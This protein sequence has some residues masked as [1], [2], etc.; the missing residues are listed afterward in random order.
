MLVD[1]LSCCWFHFPRFESPLCSG[2][3]NWR[4][5]I[6]QILNPYLDLDHLLM[7]SLV[8]LPDPEKRKVGG[9]LGMI[10]Y[11]VLFG[12]MICFGAI[13]SGLFNSAR[14]LFRR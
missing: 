5:V 12:N 11:L 10:C 6:S 7:L 13:H 8:I 1:K 14:G 9:P 4:Y 3:L 2:I